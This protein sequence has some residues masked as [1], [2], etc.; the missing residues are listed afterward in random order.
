MIDENISV[1]LLCIEAG[2]SLQQRIMKRLLS[3]LILCLFSAGLMAQV[4]PKKKSVSKQA[5]NNKAKKPAAKPDSVTLASLGP[6]EEGKCFPLNSDKEYHLY[7]FVINLDDIRVIKRYKPF[8]D[9][10]HYTFSGYV[11][12]AI[13]RDMLVDADKDLSA[14]IALRSENNAVMVNVLKYQNINKFPEYMCNIFSN[15]NKFS[16]YLQKAD[17]SKIPNY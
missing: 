11:W 1:F 8:F 16:S 2:V 17:R 14:N 13:I 4:T 9:K 5:T 15:L 10:Y 7:D 3:I 6:W 12:E